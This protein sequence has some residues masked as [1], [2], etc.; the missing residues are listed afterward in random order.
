VPKQP[1]ND[2]E[3]YYETAGQGEPLLFVHGLGS[4][5]R[6]WEEQV[7]FFAERFRVVTADLRGHGRS[8]KPPGL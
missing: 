8:E 2:I 1:V 5:G 6:D 4:S 3:L 7:P